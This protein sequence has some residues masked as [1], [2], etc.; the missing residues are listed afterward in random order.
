MGG[1]NTDTR[2]FVPMYQEANQWM[3]DHAEDPV[4]TAIKSGGSVYVEAY[5]IYGN[6]NSTVPTA[7]EYFTS[8]DV[9]MECVIK[10]NPTAAG[11]HC[12]RGVW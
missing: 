10:N 6:K 11:S 2:N 9:Q 1:S 3:Y 8:G 12:Q 5:P 7:L 4:V